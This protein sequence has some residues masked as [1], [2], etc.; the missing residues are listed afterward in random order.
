MTSL[1]NSPMQP[2]NLDSLSLGGYIVA[3]ERTM[4]QL[5]ATLDLSQEEIEVI[6]HPN[7]TA[8]DFA[9]DGEDV[10]RIGYEDG[11]RRVRW[12]LRTFHGTDLPPE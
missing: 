8:V 1:D 6:T 3:L 4:A 2:M 7:K 9:A 5:I 12:M 10:F 11:L